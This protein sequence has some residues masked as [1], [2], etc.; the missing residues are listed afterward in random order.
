MSIG[1]LRVYGYVYAC[2]VL[3]GLSRRGLSLFALAPDRIGNV[4]LSLGSWGIMSIHLMV[5]SIHGSMI[6]GTDG[7]VVRVEEDLPPFFT[8]PPA[9]I[10]PRPPLNPSSLTCLSLRGG[11]EKAGT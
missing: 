8:P 9:H 3:V 2:L 5:L 1:Q 10:P 7:R 4:W 6:W 11:L